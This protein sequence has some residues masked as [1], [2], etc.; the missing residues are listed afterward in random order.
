MLLEHSLAWQKKKDPFIIT[1]DGHVFDSWLGEICRTW[2]PSLSQLNSYSLLFFS[3]F[4]FEEKKGDS[5]MATIVPRPMVQ[6][7]KLIGTTSSNWSSETPNP[8]TPQTLL[9]SGTSRNYNYSPRENSYPRC[10]ETSAVIYQL[11]HT[12]WWWIL[13]LF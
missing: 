10:G 12:C 7:G 2:F 5:H 8:H 1:M 4:F 9:V 11:Y 13:T 6:L 3:F